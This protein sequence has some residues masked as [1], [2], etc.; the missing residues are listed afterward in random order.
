MS[1][2]LAAA[3]GSWRWGL[4]LTP[5]L[6][7]VAVLLGVLFMED[8]PRGRVEGGRVHATSYAADIKYL[9]KKSVP[10]VPLRA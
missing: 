3:A 7:L 8:P 10:F 6:G 9:V 2:Q 5:A 4:R 1:S